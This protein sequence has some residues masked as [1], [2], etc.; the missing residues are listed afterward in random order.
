MRFCPSCR[1]LTSRTGL[2]RQTRIPEQRERALSFD[3]VY[4][5]APTQDGLSKDSLLAFI[6][7]D[8]GAGVR[9]ASSADD[10]EALL[11][12]GYGLGG[13][14]YADYDDLA[15]QDDATVMSAPA[16]GA[17]GLPPTPPRREWNT[18]G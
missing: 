9:R 2:C 17:H 8:G 18:R 14:E 1:I 6:P 12:G 3:D 10:L 16:F 5:L 7:L 4:A 15:S 11:G 13:Y